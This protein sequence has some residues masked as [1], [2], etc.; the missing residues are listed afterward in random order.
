QLTLRTQLT[1]FD[2]LRPAVQPGAKMGSAWP[3]EEITLELL[4]SVVLEVNAPSATLSRT[5]DKQGRHLTSVRV[6]PVAGDPIPLE[7]R[8]PTGV[9]PLKLSISYSTKKDPRWRQWP[10]QRFLL[11]WARLKNNGTALVTQRPLPELQGGDWERGRRVF[12]SDLGT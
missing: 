10:R 12:F 6:R 9:D 3:A 11:P 8:M 4:S 1:P 7:V 5:K 2:L